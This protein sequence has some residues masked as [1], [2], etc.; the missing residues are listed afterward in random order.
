MVADRRRDDR[1]EHRRRRHRGRARR[2]RRRRRSAAPSTTST[3]RLGPI[4]V[5]VNNA[6]W[7]RIEP[8][9]DSQ[10]GDVGPRAGDQP[11]R[12]DRRDPRRARLDDRAALRPHRQHR[13]RRWAR[14][15]RR[16]KRC[17]PAPRPG[18]WASAAP[19]PVRSPAS[20]STSTRCAPA[21][22]TRRCCRRRPSRTP[23]WSPALAQGD[24]V[25]AAGRAGRDRRRRRV[26]G[27][28]RRRL[29]HRPSA[30]GLRRVDDAMSTTGSIR[31]PRVYEYR[32]TASPSITINRPD[33]LNAFRAQTCDELVEAF[34]DAW[35]DRTDRRG[36]PHRRRRPGVL[37]RRRRVDTRRGRL[38][39]RPS[40]ATTS[41]STSR[42]CT[43]SSAT[44]PSR[45]SPPSTATPSAAGTCSTSS[46]T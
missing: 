39:R 18:S 8:F 29:H 10:P 11:T 35:A 13:L 42:T 17:T 16:A 6:G 26:P 43:R 9:V 22:P 30:V 20:A 41:G 40:R 21:R 44:S 23:S 1:E 2:H 7:D 34:K 37:H 24:P 46:A 36:H 5:L 14:R 25:R 4:D 32:T 3:Q 45:S 15:A 19:S 12:P 31:G 33:K 38:R 27:V 28:R